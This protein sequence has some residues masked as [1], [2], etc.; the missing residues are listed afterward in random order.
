MMMQR[1]SPSVHRSAENERAS[2]KTSFP[3]TVSVPAKLNLFLE[4]TG[5]RSDGYHDIASLMI[6]VDLFDTLEL[7]LDT[8]GRLDL[9]CGQ[10]ELASPGNLVMRAAM[11]LREQTGCRLGAEMRLTKRIPSEAGL[12]GGSAD[13]AAAL[14]GLNELWHLDMSVDDLKNLAA[15]L[16]SDIGFFLDLPAAWCTSRGEITEPAPVGRTLHFVLVCPAVG[17]STRESY[18]RLNVPTSPRS[19]DQLRAAVAD[20][21][22]DR[23][24]RE[25]FNRLQEPAEEI[26]PLI[27]QM[28][29]R[30]ETTSAAGVAMS[31]SG[32]SL[33]ALCRDRREAL[34]IAHDVRSIGSQIE[35]TSERNIRVYPLRCRV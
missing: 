24:G 2:V 11:L 32:S 26:C 7:R 19:G 35:M 22:V 29:E 13:A 6:G 30:L 8:T 31:G 34:R 5:K 23:I 12:G 3:V 21:D 25:M 18:A 20:G 28:R 27:G 1:C 17:V 4:V 14:L 9:K 16:G 15:Q 33:F 10:V